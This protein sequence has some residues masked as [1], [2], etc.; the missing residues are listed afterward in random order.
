[1]RKGPLAGLKVVEMVG[2]G[3]GPFAAMWMADMGAEVI[4]VDRPGQRYNQT[5]ADLLNRGRRSLAVDLKKA[6]AAEVV[7]RLAAQAD[8]LIEG[9]RP[10]VMER[11]GLGP[12]SAMDRNPRLI[13]SRITGWGQN[14]P[15]AAARRPRP[16]LPRHHWH[17]GDAWTGGSSAAARL[18]T[19]WEILVA[20]ACCFFRESLPRLSSAA[21]PARDRWS[22]R[23]CSKAPA[24]SPR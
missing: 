7:L 1:M 12:D 17:S 8:V 19:L 20:G 21:Y 16:E 9:F 18:S 22:M 3:P 5:R 23:P 4:R 2:V 10:G 6:G 24:C 14:G 13:Y 11:L 15:L